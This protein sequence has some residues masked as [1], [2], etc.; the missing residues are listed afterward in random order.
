MGIS[1]NNV[2][3][4]DKQRVSDMRNHPQYE[5][6]FEDESDGDG[7]EEG[8][9]DEMFGDEDGFGDFGNDSD[10]FDSFTSGGSDSG[11]SS[12]FGSGGFGNNTSNT[13]GN[14]GFGNNG[15]GNNGFGNNS[16]G[17]NGFGGNSFGGNGFGGNGFGNNN[18]FGGFGAQPQQQQQQAQ[19]DRMDA[20][21]DASVDLAKDFGSVLGEMFHS[22][23]LR[24]ADDFGF[25]SRNLI[26]AGAGFIF[27]GIVLSLIGLAGQIGMLKFFGFSHNLVFCGALSLCSGITGMGVSALVLMKVG[28]EIAEDDN[29]D[30][31]Q[32]IPDGEDNH[33]QE[34]SDN[35][36]DILNDLFQDED[37]SGLMDDTSELQ[38]D[39]SEEEEETLELVEGDAPEMDPGPLDLTEALD[40]IQNNQ[41]VSRETLFNTFK[42]LFPTNTRGFSDTT[43][44]ETDSDVFNTLETYCIKALAIL[45][46]CEEEE[47][48][49]ELCSA[50]ENYFSY[51]LRLKRINKVKKTDMLATEIENYMRSSSDDDSVNA[52]V[53]IEGDFYKI[54]VTKGVTAVVTFGDVF[55]QQYCCDFFLNTKN[56]LPMITGINE[57]GEVIL[58]D[59][60]IFD[61]MMIAGK[62]RSG[63]SWYVLAVLASL[64]LFNPP[65]SVQFIIVDP[66]GSHLFKTLALMPHVCGLHDDSHILDILDDII[67]VEAPRRK[68]LLDAHEVDDIWGLRKKGVML[69]VLYLVID[70]YMSVLGNLGKDRREEFDTKIKIVISQLP[71]LGIRLIFVP[72]RAM[73]V[74]DKTNRTMIQFAAAVRANVDD[75][76]DTLSIQKWTRALT[77]Q[78]DVAIKSSSMKNAMFVRGAALTTSDESNST[79]I[80]TAAKAFY[81]MGV[82]LPD[83]STMRF[84]VN[85]DEDAVREQLIGNR[86]RIQYD[87]AATIAEADAI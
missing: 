34:Y 43:E 77:N 40:N 53:S 33:T 5:S 54:I 31:L 74:V 28:G 78:G 24:N 56:Q 63:K 26:M 6:G 71:S 35:I 48:N 58:E 49:S 87:A 83:M 17:N 84:A 39:D 13:A 44:I 42:P 4:A 25:L 75:V 68:E 21:V 72:H 81:K 45:A 32:D 15:F 41:V 23:K 51:E 47:V 10:S 65:E 1:L 20:V 73:G 2:S 18:G 52:T 59:A 82:D 86:N 27:A 14:N 9:F 30:S 62:P 55:Q 38:G 66:K 80:E 7:S 67:N 50:K 61:T 3:E 19:P 37:D 76:K 79:F 29:V 8:L 11:S 64:M 85:R 57:L 22:I 69:P 36:D 70:E 16:F 60:K 12:S 46:N